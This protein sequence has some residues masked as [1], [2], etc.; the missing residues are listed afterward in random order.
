MLKPALHASLGIVFLS[1]MRVI[2][3]E[4]LCLYL[5]RFFHWQHWIKTT[6]AELCFSYIAP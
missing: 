5:Q 6:K 4:N 3:P 2:T 1:K